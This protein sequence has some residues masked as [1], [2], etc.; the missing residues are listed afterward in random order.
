MH[1]N[2]GFTLVELLAVILILLGLA[3]VTLLGITNVLKNREADAIREQ[4]ELACGA[5]KIYFSINGGTEVTE[6][7]VGTLKQKG[8]FSTVSKTDTLNDSDKLKINNAT[9]IITIGETPCNNLN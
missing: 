9:K 2:K 8:Y 7:T 6:V 1:N 5:A 3:S 4:K